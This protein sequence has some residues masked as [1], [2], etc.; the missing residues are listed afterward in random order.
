MFS[1]RTTS[2]NGLVMAFLVGT[3]ALASSAC[4]TTQMAGQQS[5][6][7]RITGRI[8]RALAADPEVQRFDID[9][10][11]LDQVV[12]LRGTVETENEKQSAEQIARS[13]EGVKQVNNLLA[14]KSEAVEEAEEDMDDE[15]PSDLSLRT[16]VGAKLTA[17]PQI[18]RFNID[19]DV[20]DGVVAL[21]GVVHDDLAKAEAE[22]IARNVDGVVEVRN[23]LTVNEQDQPLERDE[24]N[25]GQAPVID[26]GN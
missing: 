5:D 11:T 26:A 15:R 9:V 22:K 12:T 1:I 7:S 17:D 24:T 20:E 4:A 14:V 19:I 16:K 8:G 2:V 23:E 6:D 18:R 13:T 3:T 25:E 21:S 10:D